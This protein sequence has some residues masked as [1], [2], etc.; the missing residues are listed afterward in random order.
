MRTG[1]SHFVNLQAA[2]AYYQPYG[3]DSWEVN[4]KIKNGEISIGP[5]VL[6]SGQK[7]LIDQ[8]EGRYFI[9]D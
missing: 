3:S 6:K 2:I 5:P 8:T 7:L 4:R 9:E 1:T